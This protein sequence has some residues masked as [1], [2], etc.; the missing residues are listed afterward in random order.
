MPI[1][2]ASSVTFPRLRLID[3]VPPLV[4]L[5]LAVSIPN[6]LSGQ[7]EQS[8]FDGLTIA[9][10][11]DDAAAPVPFGPG[12]RLT[13]KV[14]IGIF[15]AGE[16]TMDLQTLDTVRGHSTYRAVVEIDA[17][18][19]GVGVHDI[20]TTWFDQQTLQSWRYIRDIDD[21]MYESYR[22]YEFYPDRGIWDR[23]DND[24][25]GPLG[26]SLPLDEMAF[27]YYIR[28]MSLEVGKTYTLSRFFK[29]DGNPVVIEVLRKDRRETEGVWY[30][31]IVIKPTIQTDG[32]F[33]EGGD[34]ELHFTDDE[35]RLLVYLKTN[36]PIL[37]GSLTWHLRS[38]EEGVPL[39]PDARARAIEW[40]AQ[41]AAADTIPR[42]MT[43]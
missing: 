3:R 17:G 30:N 33:S 25:F 35:R 1:A 36:V 40:R 11:E 18:L 28:Q 13:Y 37:P 39:H 20:F 27:I 6:N 22:H 41:A 34:A 29:E 16:V 31:T 42:L 32:M 38:V 2:N 7:D 24:E 19:M 10:P 23:E 5:L 8:R 43:C 21:T 12:E 9:F 15:N 4:L 14:K 26:S